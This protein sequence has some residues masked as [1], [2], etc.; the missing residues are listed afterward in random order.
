MLVEIATN[1]LLSICYCGYVGFKML[2]F[3]LIHINKGTLFLST[4]S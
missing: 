2:C 4:W 1:V 3:V